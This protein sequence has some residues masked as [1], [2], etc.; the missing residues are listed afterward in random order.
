MRC[1]TPATRCVTAA[2][3]CMTMGY[4]RKSDRSTGKTNKTKPAPVKA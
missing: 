1:A 4:V 3:R 2:T